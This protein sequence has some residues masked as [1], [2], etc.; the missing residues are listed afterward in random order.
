MKRYSLTN[1]D[2]LAWKRPPRRS[3]R[4]RRKTSSRRG[5]SQSVFLNERDGFSTQYFPF[6][7]N[8]NRIIEKKPFRRYCRGIFCALRTFSKSPCSIKVNR[9]CYCLNMKQCAGYNTMHQCILYTV[10]RARPFVVAYH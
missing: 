6:E 4:R 8:S 2:G 7:L 9:Y 5:K 1:A 3:R 10:Y